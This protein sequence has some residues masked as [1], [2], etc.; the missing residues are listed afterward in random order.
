MLEEIEMPPSHLLE[1][2]GIAEPATLR[3]RELGTPRRPEC[4]VK[5]MRILGCVQHLS[6]YL[7]RRPYPKPKSNNVITV[8]YVLPSLK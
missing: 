5:F 3:T 8:H 4:N 6:D 2:M 7:P 1:I